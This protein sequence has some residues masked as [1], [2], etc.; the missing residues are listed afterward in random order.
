[1]FA[2]TSNPFRQHV[3]VS[4]RFGKILRPFSGANRAAAGDCGQSNTMGKM[5]IAGTF[6]CKPPETRTEKSKER[7]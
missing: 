3:T 5:T 7:T 4:H 6:S 2:C 1:M